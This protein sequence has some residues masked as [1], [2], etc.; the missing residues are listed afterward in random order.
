M[1]PTLEEIQQR[2]MAAC[3]GPE[4]DRPSCYNRPGF[5]SA[6]FSDEFQVQYEFRQSRDCQHWKQGGNAHVRKWCDSAGGKIT[7]WAS[8]NGCKW[9]VE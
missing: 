3:R 4:V 1:I 8:C 5:V 9:K 2:W 7:H 6:V